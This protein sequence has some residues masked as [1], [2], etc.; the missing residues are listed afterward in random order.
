MPPPVW[1]AHPLASCPRAA[2]P[3]EMRARR[4]WKA[5]LA[6]A[7]TL[8]AAPAP[9]P[10]ADVA[11][12]YGARLGMTRADVLARAPGGCR[13]PEDAP[14]QVFLQCGTRNLSAGFTA[15]GRAWW[16]TASVDL[17]GTLHTLAE[18]RT[19]LAI[20]HG[21]PKPV[22][23]SQLAWLP[24]GSRANA[25]GC[26]GDLLLFTAKVEIGGKEVVDLPQTQPG[27]LPLH[28][29]RLASFAGHHGVIVQAQDPRPRLAELRR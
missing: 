28:S 12:L 7:A 18:A 4:R 23:E 1:Q 19:A 24:A 29:A 21:E 27:C 26:V 8:A 11:D 17:T 9:D 25:E 14:R 13:P 5:V 3:A 2:T 15:A 10:L 20:R 22:G 16:V 6:S